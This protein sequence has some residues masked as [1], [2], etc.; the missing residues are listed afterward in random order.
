MRKIILI[1][2][3]LLL[4]GVKGYGQVTIGSSTPPDPSALLDLKEN[5][6]GSSTKGLL[7]P[8]VALKATHDPSPLSGHVAGMTVYNSA[9]SEDGEVNYV[10][11]GFYYNNGVQWERLHL[12]TTNWFYMPSIAFDTSEAATGVTVDLYNKFKEQFLGTAPTFVHSAGA[13]PA[14]PYVPAADKLYYYITY[15]DPAVFSNISISKSGVMTYDVT[16]AATDATHINIIFVV[17]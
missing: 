6:D 7:M 13:P 9:V 14:I 17:Q 12:G 1:G 2:F 3:L 5:A 15:Y 10:S 11:P 16:P 8:R 4:C